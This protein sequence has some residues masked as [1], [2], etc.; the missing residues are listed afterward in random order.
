[1][2]SHLKAD[3]I[4]CHLN[5]SNLNFATLGINCIDC[6]L[7][8][9]QRTQNPNHALAG[10][11][12]DCLDC[13]SLLQDK[14]SAEIFA[15]NFFPLTGGHKIGNCFSCHQTGGNFKVYLPIVIH[16]INMIMP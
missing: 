12:T 14:W 16:A 2:A 6:H 1:V 9:Y 10:F 7:S 11:S 5:Y 13:H 8:N 3:C 15:H 4:K